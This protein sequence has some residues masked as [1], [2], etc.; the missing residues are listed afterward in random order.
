MVLAQDADAVDEALEHVLEHPA[1]AADLD[2]HLEAVER[3]LALA[4]ALEV[5]GGLLE[6]AHRGDVRL[7]RLPGV[8]ALLRAAREV[9][10]NERAVVRVRATADDLREARPERACAAPVVGLLAV[11]R[12]GGD[13]ARVL[14][15]AGGAGHVVGRGER[16]RA[17]DRAARR[18]ASP[19]RA[20]SRRSRRTPC[21]RRR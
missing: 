11:D 12:G 8:A 17:I 20:S 5:V 3:A 9:E 15:L 18:A 6:E 13:E 7:A 2:E 1:L 4:D 10:L 21:T 19:W 16:A 14:H